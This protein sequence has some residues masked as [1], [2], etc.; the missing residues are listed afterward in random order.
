MSTKS[1]IDFFKNDFYSNRLK[2]TDKDVEVELDRLMFDYEKNKDTFKVT[3][4]ERRLDI[5][6]NVND[7]AEEIGR[8]Y[9]YQ[10]LVSTLP[11]VETKRGVYKG[12]VAIRKQVSKRML[13]SVVLDHQLLIQ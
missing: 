9:G 4:P 1:F 13:C 12:D 10:N 5:D 8:L 3:I 6:P 7:I 11:K 2:L